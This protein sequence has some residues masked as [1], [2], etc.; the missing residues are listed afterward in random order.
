MLAQDQADPREAEANAWLHDL[1]RFMPRDALPLGACEMELVEFAK[2]RAFEADQL[3][4]RGANME[5]LERY[6]ARYGVEPPA[7]KTDAGR[8]KRVACNLWWRRALRRAN[9]RRSE[10]LSIQLGLVHRRHGLYASHDAITRRREQ[11]RRN[12]GLLEALAAIN[13]LGQEYT[14]QELADLS[15]SNPVIRRAELMVR[16]A[17]FEHIAVGL[18]CAGEFITVTAPSKFHPRHAKSGKRNAKYNGATP[19]T[20]ATICK[21]CGHA[22]PPPWRASASARLASAWR[23]RT[24][25]ARRTCMRCCSWPRTRSKPSAPLWPA[26][27]CAKTAKSWACAM[28]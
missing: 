25:M 12:R 16:I 8:A 27:P 17:G 7:G 3:L 15:T 22:L 1:T 21:P 5:Q 24:T 28:R 18:E 6:C 9:A 2:Q 23:S 11:K 19:S 26:M 13:E 14:L 10:H 4:S 20:P